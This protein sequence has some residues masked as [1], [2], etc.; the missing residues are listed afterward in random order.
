MGTG[1]QADKLA[2]KPI[3]ANGFIIGWGFRYYL[4]RTKCRRGVENFRLE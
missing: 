4:S 2:N 1:A 3:Y